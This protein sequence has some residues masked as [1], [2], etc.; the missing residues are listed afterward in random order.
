MFSWFFY[1][2]ISLLEDWELVPYKRPKNES[3]HL[4]CTNAHASPQ[5]QNGG[6]YFL[7]LPSKSQSHPQSLIGYFFSSYDWLYNLEFWLAYVYFWKDLKDLYFLYL[8]FYKNKFE[9]P[10]D[11]L[12]AWISQGKCLRYDWI[13]RGYSNNDIIAEL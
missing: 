8:Y 4:E 9:S 7:I 1:G 6:K 12:P 3:R 2:M 13:W 11:R 10:V 5:I